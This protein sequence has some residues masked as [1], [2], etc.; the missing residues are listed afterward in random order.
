MGNIL[1]S[2]QGRRGCPADGGRDI[3]SGPGSA[4]KI[5]QK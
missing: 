2:Q 5:Y 1:I 3:W 4:R